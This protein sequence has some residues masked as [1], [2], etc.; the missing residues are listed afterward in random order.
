LVEGVERLEDQQS[1]R[2][3]EIEGSLAGRAEQI[4]GIKFWNARTNWLEI[5]RGYR[6]RRL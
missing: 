3:A 5:S 1:H 2:L 4:A 6:D